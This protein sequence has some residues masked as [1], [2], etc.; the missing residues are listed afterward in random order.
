MVQQNPKE[1]EIIFQDHPE[2][3]D[4]YRKSTRK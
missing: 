2:E 4:I 1:A 3:L